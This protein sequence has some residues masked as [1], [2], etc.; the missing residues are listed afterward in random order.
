MCFIERDEVKNTDA[1]RKNFYDALT[2]KGYNGIIDVND[3]KYSGYKAKSP[4]IAFNAGKKLALDSVTKM[5]DEEIGG[6]KTIEYIKL[7][8][9]HLTKTIL[10]MAAGATVF[11]LVTDTVIDAK[12]RDEIV[13]DYK[14]DHPGTKLSYNEILENYY[15]K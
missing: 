10:S 8:A 3:Q 14:R 1:F 12:K 2:N 7:G 5:G 11:S 13:S 4:M 15:S 6:G 9:K